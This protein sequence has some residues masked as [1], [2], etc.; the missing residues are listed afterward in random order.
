MFER[1]KIIF[2]QCTMNYINYLLRQLCQTEAQ[3]PA[4]PTFFSKFTFSLQGHPVHMTMFYQHLPDTRN[5]SATDSC[6]FFSKDNWE[7][8][9]TDTD[10]LPSHSH[11]LLF[12]SP[13]VKH[14]CYDT[15]KIYSG[16][17]TS[18]RS[19]K[20]IEGLQRQERESEGFKEKAIKEVSSTGEEGCSSGSQ[21]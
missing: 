16:Y 15:Q 5:K 7:F 20:T 11:F 9:L 12:S 6:L 1:L 18:V 14:F 8:P 21:D 2:Y 19:E 3:I 13:F 10:N 17:S 4:E